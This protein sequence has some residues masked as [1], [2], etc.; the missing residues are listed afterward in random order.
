M[1]AGVDEHADARGEQVG[2]LRL[3][4]FHPVAHEHVIDL[5]VAALPWTRARTDAE[6]RAHLWPGEEFADA[7]EVVAEG[8]L[9]A[10]DAHVVRVHPR[11]LVWR[12]QRRIARRVRGGARKL[13]EGA[14]AAVACPNGL[15]AAG[16]R[17][18]HLLVG[19]VGH[20]GGVLIC[21]DGHRG[22]VR[23]LYLRVGEAVADGH[24][25]QADRR[26]L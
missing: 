26:S 16:Y 7:R 10:L 5:E 1:V 3:V 23:V 24:A 22:V 6:G 25:L 17:L 4:V 12:H 15:D 13:G 11:H 9:G 19:R 20:G 8:R 18:L 2:N 21:R 14:G